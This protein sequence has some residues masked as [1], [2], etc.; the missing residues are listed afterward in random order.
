MAKVFTAGEKTAA[1]T[2]APAK[3]V[4]AA[5]ASVMHVC[6]AHETFS[7]PYKGHLV[8]FLQETRVICD[9]AM[10]AMI[11]ASDKVVTWES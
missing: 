10:K 7:L 9:G 4:S 1:Q 3:T 8:V 6:V 5:T 2:I 11:Q